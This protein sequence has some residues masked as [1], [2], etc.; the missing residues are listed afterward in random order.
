VPLLAR[1]GPAFRDE[2]LRE[3]E[4]HATKLIGAGSLSDAPVEAVSARDQS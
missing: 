1:Y 3:A 4:R 2:M